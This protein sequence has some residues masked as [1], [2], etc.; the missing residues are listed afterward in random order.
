[1]PTVRSVP[2]SPRS[3]PRALCALCAHVPSA[4]CPLLKLP[5]GGAPA[6]EAEG[7]PLGG[8]GGEGRS[9]PGAKAGVPPPNY[10]YFCICYPPTS[11]SRSMFPAAQALLP[12]SVLSS[13]SPRRRPSGSQI[14]PLGSR[15]LAVNPQARVT[16][17]NHVARCNRDPQQRE[18]LVLCAGGKV[19]PRFLMLLFFYHLF[20]SLNEGEGR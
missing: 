18:G 17:L 7:S 2:G 20:F 15:A 8:R 1:M 5:P 3:A 4:R 19:T 6:R 12:A 11:P 10:F 16:R 9:K 13:W 14:I